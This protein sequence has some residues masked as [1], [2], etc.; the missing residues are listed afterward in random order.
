M[1]RSSKFQTVS[2]VV[3]FHF[4]ALLGGHWR[5]RR[6]PVKILFIYLFFYLFKLTFVMP[7]PVPHN[8]ASAQPIPST[9]TPEMRYSIIFCKERGWIINHLR[10][11]TCTVYDPGGILQVECW[12]PKADPFSRLCGNIMRQASFRNRL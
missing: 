8:P 12:Q 11:M 7:L 2:C 6:N 10:V 4:A 9:I 3:R 5:Y 1:Q